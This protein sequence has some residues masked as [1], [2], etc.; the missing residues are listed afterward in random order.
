MDDPV[1]FDLAAEILACAR[2]ELELTSAGAPERSC[3]HVGEVAHDDCCD[4]P[5]G[6]LSVTI[7]RVYPSSS[8][9]DDDSTTL[10]PCG[11][12]FAAVDLT[13]QIVRCAPGMSDDG[14]PP[15]C[16]E[17]EAGARVAY[18]DARA[19]W[20][21]V[22]CCLMAMPLDR[23]SVVGEQTFIGPEGGCQ[24][25]S[26]TITIGLIDGCECD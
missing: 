16:A 20:K 14:K 10:P 5:G 3:V 2:A 17:I 18:L 6:Q 25:S 22:R 23:T 19:I 11:P 13:V 7:T 8:F 24:G 21:G 9:P 26:L 12:P 15:T 1:L 4:P